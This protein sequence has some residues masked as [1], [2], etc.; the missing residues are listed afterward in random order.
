[1]QPILVIQMQRMGDLILSFPLLL[2]L[3]RTFPGHPLWVLAEPQFAAPLSRLSP[4]VTYLSWDQQARIRQTAFHVVINL[5]HRA[6]ARELA[7]SLHCAELIGSHTRHGVTRV[8][9]VWQEYRE[10]LVHNNRHNRFHW[11]DLN[12]LDIIP[13]EVMSGTHWQLPRSQPPSVR[14][15]G[16]FLGASEEHKRPTPTFWTELIRELERRHWVPVLLGGPA[17]QE[18]CR[19]VQAMVGRPVASACGR[20]GL[21]QFASFGQGLAAMIT[22]DT[23]PMHLAAW[24]GL[25]TLNLSMGS[26][27]AWETGPYQPEHVVLRS[28]RAC[29]GCW[30]CRFERPLCHDDF[31]PARVVRV[32]ETMLQRGTALG[33]VRLPGLEIM[34]TS[35]RHGLYALN[36]VSACRTATAL[37]G[38]Y[39]QQFWLQAFAPGS[40]DGVHT[41]AKRMR[42]TYPGLVRTMSRQSVQLFR[43][44][45]GT[46]PGHDFQAAAW[47][48]YA[49]FLRPLSGYASTH[50]GNHD[51]NPSSRRRVLEMTE[52]HL[53]QLTT[54]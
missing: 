39:W 14:R 35:R 40:T 37:L 25:L 11:A 19:Q 43:T 2:W 16:L 5:S 23:G 17:D 26:V 48:T 6:H 45:S 29:V 51:C 41:A 31:Q 13:A 52:M 49:P 3:Q 44:L 38:D 42:E 32:L 50:L 30:Q 15:I 28:S 12:A 20:L 46:A 54:P 21:E 47:A 4:A 9:G 8:R 24:T 10:S 27:H 7:G 18:L 34:G 1:M 53:A 22:P 33:R 36:S